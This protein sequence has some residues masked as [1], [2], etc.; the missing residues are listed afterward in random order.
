MTI[1]YDEIIR[2]FSRRFVSL[3]NLEMRLLFYLCKFNDGISS[4]QIS[5]DLS[6]DRR[7]LL[8]LRSSI[9]Q[10][11]DYVNALFRIFSEKK[12]QKAHYWKFV[13]VSPRN[14]DYFV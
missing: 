8:L 13:S 7:H 3:S 12:K 1:D 9:N 14:N 2:I 10:K 5:D 4:V 6:I 11:L